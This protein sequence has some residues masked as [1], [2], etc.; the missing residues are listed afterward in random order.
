MMKEPIEER[1]EP[2]A[3]LHDLPA[4][5][6]APP[7]LFLNRELSTLEFNRRVLAQARD[8]SL[9]L[10]ERVRFLTISSS[11]LDE[12]FEIRVGGLKQQLAYGLEEP[13][14]DGLEPAE[15]LERIA[16]LG[17]ELVEEQYRL[18]RDELLPE[19]EQEQIRL[20]DREDWDERQQRWI[21]RYFKNEVLPVLAPMGL[22]PAHPFP[23]ILN[24]SLN[25]IVEV[26]GRDAYGREA[27]V[28]IV[29]VPR[30]LPRLIALPSKIA[31]GEHEF[32]L[33]SSIVHAHVGRL[34]G[35]MDIAGCYQ[36][37]LTRNSDLWVDEEEV[38]DLLHALKGQLSRRHYGD[39]V[40]LEV[41]EDCS[42]G[43]ARTLLENFGLEQRDLYRVDGP[44]NLNRLSALVDLID[45][46]D[47]KYR[48][49][50]P[51][52]PPELEGGGNLFD[53]LRQRDV[54]L[55]HPFQ[56]FQ[57]VVELVRQAAD[58]PNVLAIK[59]TVYRTGHESPIIQALVDA[60]RAGKE[61]TVVVELRAR[62]DEASN[63][64]LATQLQ[65]AGAKV[66]YGIVG[67]KAHA[68]MMLVVRREGD[69]LVRYVHL[70]T[71]NYHTGTARAYTDLSLLTSDRELCE[72]VHKVFLQLTAFGKV[73]R[74]SQILQAPFT[75]QKTLLRRIEEEIAAAERGEPARIAA[76]MNSL[77]DPAMIRSLYRAS[78]AGVRVDLIVRGIC[79]LRPGVPGWSENI[80]VRSILGRFLEHTRVYCFHAGGETKVY[81]SSADWMERNLYRRVETC[82]PLQE[83]ALRERV[84]DECL[85][86]YLA[87]D[88]FDEVGIPSLI[89]WPLLSRAWP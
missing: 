42:E 48:R 47:L 21:A 75:L 69:E 61:V 84:I 87:D 5:P 67:H 39:G 45:R 1:R 43:M 65:E 74:L 35:G 24:K 83:R 77:S 68:K 4:E 59:Q 46:A 2:E 14:P 17:H 58:D 40:R 34:F 54:L 10:L 88:L 7:E 50:V 26:E 53:V 60:A 6:T 56:S 30:S 81:A 22:D 79:C 3:P 38:E 13:G 12:F 80:H 25:F 52:L 31:N 16:V 27:R 18:L 71:G 62:F 78:Q 44:V 82:F 41:A 15:V 55:H 70:G 64:R 73:R 29:Q 32:V 11:N 63:I 49:F 57:P 89:Q 36:F 23:R 8:R 51:G 85:E 76:K 66:V 72:D 9:P 86:A 28:A 33:L 37:R 20:L 19:L